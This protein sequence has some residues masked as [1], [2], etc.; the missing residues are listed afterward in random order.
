MIYSRMCEHAISALVGVVQCGCD[1]EWC[2]V[3]DIADKSRVP[4]P[5]L[6]K[7]LRALTHHRFLQSFKGPIGGFKL[8]MS[9]EKITLYDVVVAIDGMENLERC[10]MGWNSCD[11]NEVKCPMHSGWI[12]IRSQIVEFLKTTTLANISTNVQ[13]PKKEG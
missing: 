6:S 12:A 1:T 8:R 2:R 9:A 10:V 5:T 4:I 7:V 3:K 11:K 13:Y